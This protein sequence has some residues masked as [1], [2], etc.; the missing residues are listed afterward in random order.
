MCCFFAF[1]YFISL[2]TIKNVSCE[3]GYWSFLCVYMWKWCCWRL[4]YVFIYFSFCFSYLLYYLNIANLKRE[5]CCIYNGAQFMYSI[6]WKWVYSSWT[7]VA[8]QWHM[9][10]SS[11][12]QIY[13]H[14]ELTEMCGTGEWANE[15]GSWRTIEWT[16]K[17]CKLK[18]VPEIN[19]IKKAFAETT[20]FMHV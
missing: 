3:N 15:L 12:Q 19:H 18:L 14:D 16:N 10:W 6:K 11:S 9:T 8:V 17:L 7:W 20:N 5:C 1:I 4:C 13:S 2:K